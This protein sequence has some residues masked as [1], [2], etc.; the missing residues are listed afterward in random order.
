VRSK[1][2]SAATAARSAELLF[3]YGTLMR[4]FR[5]HRLLAGRA[6]F[7]THG[8]VPARIIDLG[9]YPGAVPDPEAA[10]HGEVYR[11]VDP[12]LWAALDS[13]EG[14]QYHRRVVTVRSEAGR[15]LAASIYWYIGPLD[16][17]VPIPG[18]DYR[19]HAPATSIYHQSL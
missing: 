1:K 6:E 3:T 16:R 17:G 18:G 4:G 7:L 14:P 9:S 10:I 5:L 2:P 19:A 12:A 8:Q 15:E 11:V 13:A